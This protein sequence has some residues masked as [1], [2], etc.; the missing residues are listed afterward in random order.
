MVVVGAVAALA[1]TWA[2][3]AR[4]QYADVVR[5]D[6]PLAYWRLGEPPGSTVAADSSG[7]GRSG[8]YSGPT[9]GVTGA[10]N[11]RPD[12]AASFDGLNDEVSMG[13]MLDFSGSAAFSL[14][15]WVSQPA[16]RTIISKYWIGSGGGG[17]SAPLSC[18]I[19]ETTGGYSLYVAESV[20]Y[21]LRQ[22]RHDDGCGTVTTE[23]QRTSASLPGG[24]QWHH[25]VAT[26]DGVTVRLYVDGSLRSALSS[27]N[28]S[29]PDTTQ[30][31]TVGNGYGSFFQGPIDEV[32]V[33]GYALGADKVLR[34]Y[35]LAPGPSSLSPPDGTTS[36]NT[37]PTLSGVYYDPDPGDLGY[38]EFEVY[39]ASDNALVTSGRGTLA[40]PGAASTWTVPAETLR[41]GGNYYWR[42]RANDEL[43]TS[44]WSSNV[45]YAV[46]GSGDLV[47]YHLDG[48]DVVESGPDEL[49]DNLVAEIDV[50]VAS[51]NLLIRE[52]DVQLESTGLDVEITR[53]YN[54]LSPR[55]GV[56]GGGWGLATGTDLRLKVLSDGSAV[57]FGPTGYAE[58]FA[59]QPNG[60][61]ARAPGVPGTLVRNGDGTYT[62]KLDDVNETL[63]FPG[64]GGPT[65]RASEDDVRHALSYDVDGKLA[66]ITDP[67]GRRSWFEYSP[68]G[69]LSTIREPGGAAHT[70]LPHPSGKLASY[71]D[72]SG[73]RSEFDYSGGQLVRI[74]DRRGNETRFT[75]DGLGR[76]R[77]RT[78]V[79]DAAT[80][81]GPTTLYAYN[82]GNTVVTE[83]SGRTTTYF[84]DTGFVVRRAET[85][86]GP[87]R[88]LLSGTLRDRDNETLGQDTAYGLHIEAEDA[89]G[90]RAIDI[91]VD[92]DSH[93]DVVC[94]TTT[95]S[96]DWSFD[97]S[98]YTPGDHLV[99]VSATDGAGA[100]TMYA[101][102]VTV[103]SWPEIPAGTPESDTDAERMEKARAFRQD[104]GLRADDAWI[105]TVNSDPAAQSGVSE[106]GVPLTAAEFDEMEVRTQLQNDVAF[107]ANYVANSPSASASYAGT[108]IDQEQGLVYVGFTENA[109]QHIAEIA[110]VFPLSSRLRAFM[111]A[112]T[113]ATLEALHERISDDVPLLRLEGIDVRAVITDIDTNLV[114]VGVPNP[115]AITELRLQLRYGFGVKI[116]TAGWPQAEGP[117]NRFSR[118]SRIHAGLNLTPPNQPDRN[119]EDA[120]CTAGFSAYRRTRSGMRYFHTTAGHCRA[121]VWWQ[122]GRR[123]GQTAALYYRDGLRV[124][125][126]L[127]D[128]KS[129]W[130]TS[131]FIF[132]PDFWRTLTAIEREEPEEAMVCKSGANTGITCGRR[133]HN[134]YSFETEDG[135]WLRNQ[136]LATYDSGVGDSGAPV[137]RRLRY[138]KAM[139]VGIHFGR[140]RV[141]LV[142][143]AARSYAVYGHAVNE[144]REMDVLLC[145]KGRAR[146]GR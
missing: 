21:F 131:I 27:P 41:G 72:P 93:A 62:L 20:V 73:R 86:S 83:P 7:Y 130:R 32:A 122:H 52:H 85:G 146:C 112:R 127:I 117:W 33:Y 71:T 118:Y 91:T 34:H 84:H 74:K 23:T 96:F 42:A 136:R 111:A 141:A 67:D 116:A 132:G 16:A 78:S 18:G 19:P 46:S 39:R 89:D 100:R 102:L 88:V 94:S 143:N 10:P 2:E 14:E 38:L 109:D 53:F 51:G 49:P 133:V 139:A 145:I 24:G 56:L 105:T 95:C 43:F 142:R 144:E 59:R 82:A 11:A 37:A 26:Y 113:E 17:F 129:H 123:I 40:S 65:V 137:Y 9:L 104:F 108:Y 125:A 55:D 30:R 128:A 5:A 45:A 106:F 50:N 63:T 134:A 66:F 8:T 120:H 98:E 31:L 44:A 47:R 69:L 119:A 81:S 3:P 36:S 29:L 110:K 103:P 13:D 99:A 101:I 25:V 124:D 79:T 48:D 57:L 58:T 97:T 90:I 135:V 22:R 76:V 115:D 107:I 140:D 92:G 28:A 138:R 12:T 60:S 54:S 114:Y 121:H 64:S 77:S 126:Q 61:F 4:A 70:Y 6:Q 15:A 80:G 87:P 35:N 1:A 75:Y 68:T